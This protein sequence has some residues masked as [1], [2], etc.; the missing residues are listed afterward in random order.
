MRTYVVEAFINHARS[1]TNDSYSHVQNAEIKAS[2]AEETKS[3]TASS[4]T[5]KPKCAR[6]SD[7]VSSMLICDKSGA[8]HT[9][10]KNENNLSSSMKE[11]YTK[12][13]E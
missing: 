2:E 3:M 8:L 13:K 6:F 9:V 1:F 5:K 12:L 11:I 7:L 4:L 10:F